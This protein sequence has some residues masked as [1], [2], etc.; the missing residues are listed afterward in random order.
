MERDIDAE[1]PANR[2]ESTDYELIKT[3]VGQDCLDG[4]QAYK[5]RE[6]EIDRLLNVQRRRDQMYLVIMESRMLNFFKR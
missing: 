3:N 4:F 6:R 2:E 1:N 5:D